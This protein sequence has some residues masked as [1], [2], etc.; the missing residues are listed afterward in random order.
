MP[1]A[2]SGTRTSTSPG[3]TRTGPAGATRPAAGTTGP[4]CR[5]RRG[6]RR[7]RAGP[8]RCRTRTT[9]RSPRRTSRRSAPGVPHPSAVPEAFGDTPLVNGA[10]YPYLTVRPRAYRFRILNACTDRSLNLQLYRARSDGR[11]GRPT[12]PSPT[13]AAGRCRWCAAV[14]APDRPADWPTD[15]RDG[16]VPDPARRRTGVRSRSATRP[17]CCPPRWCCR[18]GRSAY[19]YDR[20]DPTVLNVDGHTLLLAPGERADVLVDFSTVPPGSTLIL[21]NDCPAPLPGFDPRY[22]HHTD[23]PDRTAEGGPPPTRAGVRAEHPHPAP[24]PGGR[25]RRP[26]RTTW[27]G[28]GTGCPGRT[29]PAS[30]RRSCRS[31]R[32]TR[33]SAPGPPGTR[34]VPVH[35][36]SVTFTPAGGAPAGH[37][38]ARGQ[39]RPA[40]LRAASTAGWPAGSASGTRRPGRSPRPPCRSVRPTRPPR[41]SSSTDPA[42]PVGAP[43]DGTQLWRISGSARQTQPLRFGGCDVQLVNRVG[44]DGTVRLAARRR[45]WAGRRSSGS[46]PREDV[47][48]ALRPLAAHS[49]VQAR[50]QR[51]AARPGAPGRRPD[52]LHPG[53]PGRRATGA[54]GEP[55]GQPG[56]GVP[57]AQP[58]GRPPGPGH[59]PAAGAAGRPQGAD[60]ADR[61]PGARARPPRCRRSRWPGPATAAARRPPVT[62]CNGPPTP[63]SP[64]RSR[65]HRGGRRRPGT[66]T[67]RSPRA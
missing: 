36:T 34:L 7:H 50:R 60:R 63:P 59:E 52:R 31:R 62:C 22:D 4:W 55:A 27:P 53:Q 23:A 67:R 18:T 57:L 32:T 21:Y 11:C 17:G 43:A 41:C 16:G 37:P 61:H 58:A 49:A 10:A 44:W 25:R 26:R 48:V 51:P 65:D 15:G 3:R 35:A 66:P 6:R 8:G 29:R 39:G 1:G 46:N 33:P 28:Y 38:A 45:S 24:V 19:R 56:L 2:A 5:A 47:V 12:G 20:L 64:A 54:G 42:V 13:P 40:G 9:T 14:R 30:A